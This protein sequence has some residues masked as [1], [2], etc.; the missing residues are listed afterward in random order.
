MPQEQGSHRD[1]K[2]SAAR[3]PGS[4]R[5]VLLWQPRR[6]SLRGHKHSKEGTEMPGPA[7]TAAP[8]GSPPSKA[9]TS[10]GNVCLQRFIRAQISGKKEMGSRRCQGRTAMKGLGLRRL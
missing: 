4:A 10:W 5:P 6:G 3:L 9:G 8:G 2:C 7:V 1:K